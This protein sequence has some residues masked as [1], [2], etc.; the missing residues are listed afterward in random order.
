M[1]GKAAS[2]GSVAIFIKKVEAKR[3]RLRSEMAGYQ[4]FALTLGQFPVQ[5]RK[6]EGAIRQ[7]S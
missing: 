3:E 1:R 2:I 4:G 6:K 5:P 7:E